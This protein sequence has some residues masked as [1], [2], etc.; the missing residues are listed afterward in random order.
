[1]DNVIDTLLN[2]QVF[3]YVALLVW[4]YFRPGNGDRDETE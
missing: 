2:V 4:L 1:M 3:A